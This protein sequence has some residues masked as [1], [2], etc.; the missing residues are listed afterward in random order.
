VL[1]EQQH[2]LRETVKPWP[3]PRLRPPTWSKA[4]WSSTI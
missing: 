4:P 1:L 2:A 3:S